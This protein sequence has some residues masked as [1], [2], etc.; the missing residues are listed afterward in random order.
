MLLYCLYCI[1]SSNKERLVYRWDEE[2]VRS[3][4]EKSSG[5]RLG[6]LQRTLVRGSDQSAATPS[7]KLILH[8]AESPRAIGPM[9][10][11]D[12]R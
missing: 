10:P 12:L 4:V 7:V 6:G 9:W 1:Q 3:F 8:N 2:S 11:T 5:A